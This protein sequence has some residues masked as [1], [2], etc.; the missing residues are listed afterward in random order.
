MLIADIDVDCD[1]DVS[2]VGTTN[3]VLAAYQATIQLSS[4]LSLPMYSVKK[5][6]KATYNYSLS[7]K[8]GLI[9]CGLG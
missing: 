3:G 2:I 4:S 8:S 9:G 1:V 7:E 5:N 6:L